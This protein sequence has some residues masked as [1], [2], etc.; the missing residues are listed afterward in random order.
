MPC[1]DKGL[2][3]EYANMEYDIQ[4][5]SE[6]ENSLIKNAASDYGNAYEHANKAVL[7]FRGF[8][9]EH[10]K[11]SYCFGAFLSFSRN[12]I[13]LA[14][15]SILRKHDVQ[16]QLMMRQ[17]LESSV[18][19]AYSMENN[20]I[21]AFGKIGEDGCLEINKD[22]KDKAYE[23]IESKYPQTSKIIKK[24]KKDI[25]KIGAH[26]NIVSAAMNL[27]DASP[28]C[29]IEEDHIIKQRLWWIGNV[30]MGIVGLLTELNKEKQFFRV[31][32]DYD[33][34]LKTLSEENDALKEE[35]MS[36]PRFKQWLEKV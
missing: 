25:N 15:L 24:M 6:E 12:S 17:F 21:E 4:K 3:V 20:S 36:N 27:R 7:F 35:L 16:C 18:F 9:K 33:A 23:W 8:M 32:D 14:L 29:D 22:V 31:I 2:G 10:D 26:A 34:Q 11:G 5:I 1:H 30:V 19:A 28:E 13:S